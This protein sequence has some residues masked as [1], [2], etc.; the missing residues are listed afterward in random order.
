MN[1]S[2]SKED[3][4]RQAPCKLFQQVILRT[5][6]SLNAFGTCPKCFWDIADH[7]NEP[8]NHQA[9]IAIYSPFHIIIPLVVPSTFEL[10]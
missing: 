8:F 9:G 1:N 10:K 2:T 3:L 7:E 4:K 5:D 6:L